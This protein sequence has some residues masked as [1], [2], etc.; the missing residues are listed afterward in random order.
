LNEHCRFYDKRIGQ[1]VTLSGRQIVKHMMSQINEIVEGEYNHNGPAIV[2][3]DTDSCYFSAYPILK[4]QIDNNELEWNKDVC[5]GLYDSIAEQTNDTFPAFM[6]RALHAPRKNGEIIKAGRELIGDRTIF[7]TK[8]R[9]AINIFDKEGKRKD[10][11]GKLGDIKAMGLDLKRADTPKYVQEF[12][13]NILSMVIQQGKGRD[14]V[15]EAIKGFKRILSAQDSWT[16]GSP[17]SVNKL[18][19][20][21]ELE[22]K[23]PTG[24]ANMPGHV[25]G[26]LNYN[27]LRRVNSDN[28]SM[29][30]VDGMKV[31]VCKLKPNPLNFTSIAYPTD[32]L[33]LPQ[34]FCEL[35][36]DD[37]EM[38]RTLVDEKIENLLGVLGW[39]LRSNTDTNSTFDDLFSFG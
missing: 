33:R 39:D 7:I 19:Y 10:K 2:Y 31:I 13:M 38:E 35:P 6:E 4:T 23:S 3:G 25:R 36:F 26:A 27:Y 37:S 18:T 14:E 32:E 1:S 16:K 5:I 34:W 15:I 29:K 17:K 12:L 9:Y 20:Y 22:K 11:D 28:Y 30:I 21:E 24:R 8:K